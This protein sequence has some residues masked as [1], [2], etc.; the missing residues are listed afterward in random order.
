MKNIYLLMLIV[1]TLGL[2]ACTQNHS[3]AQTRTNGQSNPNTN[4]QTSSPIQTKL[5]STLTEK[6][7]MDFAAAKIDEVTM[8]ISGKKYPFDAKFKLQVINYLDSY[9]K[10]A[11]NKVNRR[12]FSDDLNFVFQYGAEMAPTIN[13]AFDKHGV[14]RVS[15]LYIAMIETEFNNELVS[16]TGATGVFQLTA[17]QAKK[18]GMNKKDRNDL[19]KAAEAAARLVAA[20]QKKFESDNMKEFLAILAYNRDPQSISDDLNRKLITDFKDCSL[21]AMTQNAAVLD[22]QFQNESVKYIP[23]FLAAAIIGENPQDFGLKTK[24]LSTLGTAAA[25]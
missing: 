13:A 16:P 2:S 1:L 3:N 15:G 20:N 11:G 6:E 19:M 9:A 5:F 24:P 21:C 14:S 7:K 8:K 23:K 22:E 17:D 10:R 12:F 18:F 25:Q 4:D